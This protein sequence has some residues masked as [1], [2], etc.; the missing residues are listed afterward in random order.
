MEKEVNNAQVVKKFR[1]RL[2]NATKFVLLPD[3][4]N[5]IANYYLC[6]LC[7]HPAP[8][9]FCFPTSSDFLHARI[10][11]FQ[12][13]PTTG[14]STMEIKTTINY[15]LTDENRTMCTSGPHCFFSL[16][17]AYRL[18]D[19]IYNENQTVRWSLRFED[20]TAV[21]ASGNMHIGVECHDENH[22]QFDF[23]TKAQI[24][25]ALTWGGNIYGKNAVS[26]TFTFD[27]NLV[28]GILKCQIDFNIPESN[29]HATERTF[30]YPAPI[31]DLK[32]CHIW[33]QVDETMRFSLLYP[34]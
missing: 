27:A 20:C 23:P 11:N 16:R 15:T 12:M 8:Y 26:F 34:K 18:G 13:N 32:K 29:L 1:E 4:L 19:M 25:H 6:F 30:V 14:N 24:Y 2:E 33:V 7:W 10:Q 5:L 21:I 31:P 28:T 9:G 22:H 17:S 3:L